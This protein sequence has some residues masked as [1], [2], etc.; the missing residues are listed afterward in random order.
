MSIYISARQSVKQSGL[1]IILSVYRQFVC[2]FVFPSI[3]KTV[4]WPVCPSVHQLVDPSIRLSVHKSICSFIC[5]FACLSVHPHSCSPVHLS[6]YP[7]IC[8]S[9]HPSV[10]LSSVYQYVC[11]DIEHG[12]AFNRRAICFTPVQ[13][14]NSSKEVIYNYNF[15]SGNWLNWINPVLKKVFLWKI[16]IP[17][18]FSRNSIFFVT[19]ESSNKLQCC[20]TL[21]WN[22][23]SPL[24]PFLSYKENKVL[25]TPLLMT[26]TIKIFTQINI[27]L[28]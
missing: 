22:G 7:S 13:T 27:S 2:L 17:G 15:N 25:W 20:V 9:I 8:P 1:S 14:S 6:V 19:Y 3:C 16:Q 5:S 26:N 11:G 18:P 24:D 23:S 10:C 28:P 4:H 21:G 12:A